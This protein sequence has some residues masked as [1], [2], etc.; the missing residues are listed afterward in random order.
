LLLL[1]GVLLLVGIRRLPAAY[2]LF[3]LPQFVL[4]ATRIQPT[5]LTST[6]RY[7]LVIFPAFVVLALI[8]WQRVRIAWAI[9]SL[10][11]LAVLVQEFQRG[12]YVA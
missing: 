9:T 10:L 6:S 11:F 7:L 8:P 4:L 1:F 2:T 12:S 5:P 3:A